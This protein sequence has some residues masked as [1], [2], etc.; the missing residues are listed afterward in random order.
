MTTNEELVSA[1]KAA[2]NAEQK[3]ASFYAHA[4]QNTSDPRGKN[5][6]AQL[7]QFENAHFE[8]L[9][10]YLK[11][12]DGGEFNGYSGTEFQKIGP[13]SPKEPLSQ[14][15]LQTDIDALK[16]GI[17]AEKRAEENYRKMAGMTEDATVS[18]F[19]AKLAE[20]ESLHRKVLE[21]QFY[22]LANNGH[23]TWGE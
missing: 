23:W 8:A 5:M 9:S 21:D 11:S 3:A 15:V 14:Q 20:E 12:L 22:G 17:D 13:E 18:A 7:A 19:F 10:S 4:E 16:V 1:V 6:F 2:M